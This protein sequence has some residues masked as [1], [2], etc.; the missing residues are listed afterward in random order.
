MLLAVF[1]D[2][3][4]TFDK[5]W[6][7]TAPI[8]EI[9]A[10]GLAAWRW[11]P[12]RRPARARQEQRDRR[13]SADRLGAAEGGRSW[14]DADYDRRG[15]KIAHAIGAKRRY[16]SL[17]G[18]ALSPG[19]AVSAPK[20][21]DEGRSSISPTGCFRPSTR[22]SGSRRTSIG[23]GCAQRPRADRRGAIRPA[24][25]C[26]ATGSRC[27]SACSRPPASR[28]VRL[29]RRARAA[30]SRLGRA[31]GKGAAGRARRRLGRTPTTAPPPVVDIEA[32]TAIDVSPAK[33]IVRSRRS[34]VA[35]RMS[36]KFPAELR[37]SISTATILRPCTCSR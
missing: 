16:A 12:Q 18:P 20:D 25:S 10:D 32:G 33:A 3:R 13:R 34:R 21:R 28:A 9:R 37:E 31:G 14:D 7:W 4:E 1:A 19:V 11:R 36:D 29:R 23:R 6:A 2:D 35:P 22:S 26:R 8:C 17:F 15:R 30:L 5:L 24:T 27:K